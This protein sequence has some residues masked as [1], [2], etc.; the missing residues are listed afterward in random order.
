M[1]GSENHHARSPDVVTTAHQ[2]RSYG[3]LV[4]TDHRPPTPVD[5][6]A[7]GH[8]DLVPEYEIRVAGRLPQRWSAWFDDLTVATEADGT[9]VLRGAVVDQAALHGL[10]QK[11]RDAGIPL[12]SLAQ[13]SSTEPVEP[14]ARTTQKE[15]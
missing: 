13:I 5:D 7:A 12:I 4:N 9:S 10:I 11:L 6:P 1:E 14:P 15:N 8:Q 3:P 2:V